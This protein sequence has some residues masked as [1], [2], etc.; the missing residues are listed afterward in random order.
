M[1]ILGS[2]ES[3]LYILSTSL[4]YP[5]VIGLVALVF[6]VIVHAGGFL[7]ELLDRRRREQSPVVER[8]RR[9][10]EV[11]AATAGQNAKS[12]L[13]IIFERKLQKTELAL[14]KSL[15]R[16]RCV[17]RIGPSFGLMGTLIPM[18]VALASLAQGDMPAMASSMVTAFTTTIV[19]LAC[20]VAAYMIS[21]SREKWVREDI[22]ELEYLCESVLREARPGRHEMTREVPDEVHAAETDN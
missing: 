1:N 4:F 12:S 7:R 2:F 14:V 17:V 22:S 20:G 6:W 21:L 10:V 15:D 18:G 8:F 16:I 5:V 13:D 3:F 11:E 19:G 9:E